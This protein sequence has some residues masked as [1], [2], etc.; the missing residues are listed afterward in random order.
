MNEPIHQHFVPRS[1]LKNFA[2][3]ENGH[4]LV[5]SEMRGSKGP[6][7]MNIKSIC[8]K[9]NLYTFP[10]DNGDKYALERFYGREVDGV[11]PE[12]YKIL[13]DPTTFNISE[14]TKR[15]ILNTILS[16]F[17][18]TPKFLDRK[19]DQLT[20]LLDRIEQTVTNPDEEIVLRS[21]KGVEFKFLKK[22]IA[23][24]RQTLKQQNKQDFLID[25]FGEWQ[26]FVDFKLNCGI[27][28]IKVDSD[29]PL[30]TSDN[31]VLVM[32]MKGKLN[33]D[34]VFSTENIL[35]IPIDREHYVIIYPQIL[36]DKDDQYR[37]FRSTR[38]KYF[39]AGVNLRTEQN[40]ELRIIGQH[41]D[42]QTH[43]DSQ[44]TLGALTSENVKAMSVT[45]EKA[46]GGQELMDLFAEHGTP[47]CQ[48]VADK[49]K[50]MRKNK[51][52]NNDQ[53]LGKLI[54]GLAQR[55]FWTV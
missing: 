6:I 37:I 43:L 15:K 7:P 25:H 32:D 52:W 27:E 28:V 34:N 3:E 40:S 51:I 16:L 21:K 1:Y 13:T 35:E 18:R 9:K 33:G 48:A 2:I 8:A 36:N 12:V 53:M 38:D 23:E 55:G 42:L 22:D 41:G 45:I 44:N 11:Y 29:V 14:E 46:A 10:D 50:E 26:K 49:V 30:I 4:F 47:Y 20:K 24:A 17:F 19:N 54:L 31:P 39:A 5:D